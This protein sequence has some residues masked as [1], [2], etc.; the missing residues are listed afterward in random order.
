MS[1]YQAWLSIQRGDICMPTADSVNGS[2][3]SGHQFAGLRVLVA[4]DSWHVAKA[5]G[6]VLQ[7]MGMFVV[8]P[9]ACV[10]SA[11]ALLDEGMP[12]L[13]VVDV[14]LK[15]EMSYKLIDLLQHKGVPVIVVTGYAHPT[16]AA[17]RA[18]AVLQK[19]FSGPALVTSIH[20]VLATGRHR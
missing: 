4:E 9:A 5:L 14:N 15:G 8:G 1:E 3:S 13:A 16:N 17:G 10:A 2:M 18:H 12:D 6:S 7:D 19:P 11:R 20:Q